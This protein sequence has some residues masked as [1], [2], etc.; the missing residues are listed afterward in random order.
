MKIYTL[1]SLLLGVIGATYASSNAFRTQYDERI[2]KALE[3]SKNVN[4]GEYTINN[5]TLPKVHCAQK[6]ICIWYNFWIGIHLIPAVLLNVLVIF[7]V[8]D[9]L[10]QWKDVT[11]DTMDL[12]GFPWCYSRAIIGIAWLMGCFCLGVAYWSKK[13]IMQ[14]S[15]QLDDLI[16]AS[17]KDPQPAPNLTDPS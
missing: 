15:T 13:K 1:V 11:N 16:L 5:K 2:K 7:I 8:G 17:V 3:N 6:W 12:T 10:L 9:A 4:L 14:N